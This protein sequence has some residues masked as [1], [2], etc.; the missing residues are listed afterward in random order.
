MALLERVVVPMCV[1][2]WTTS[3]DFSLF[4]TC[5]VGAWK[6]S[7]EVLPKLWNL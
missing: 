1:F 5:S 2:A 3:L 4:L 7:A 6:N